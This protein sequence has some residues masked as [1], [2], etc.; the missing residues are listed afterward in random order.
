MAKIKEEIKEQNDMN[1]IKEE[2]T[3]Y[4]NIQIK[5][6]FTEELEKANKRLIR[7]KNKKIFRKDILI[8]ILF[9]IIILLIYLLYSNHYFD[10]Y[11]NPNSYNEI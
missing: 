3:D 10:K 1:I 4:I 8:I 5:K 11:F 6:G 7:E 2:L 9:L